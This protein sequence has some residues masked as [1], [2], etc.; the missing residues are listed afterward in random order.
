[1]FG[2][3]RS[4]WDGVVLE[5]NRTQLTFSPVVAK[6]KNKGF[7]ADIRLLCCV[8]VWIS[9]SIYGWSRTPAGGNQWSV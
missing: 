8:S 6:L 1:M 4:E 5:Y 3:E 2:L 9:W 7:T